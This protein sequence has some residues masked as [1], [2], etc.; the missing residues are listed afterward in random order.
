MCL[1]CVLRTGMV[2]VKLSPA[3][4]CPLALIQYP[5]ETFL[6]DDFYTTALLSV[7][8]VLTKGGDDLLTHCRLAQH[9]E[10]ASE[11]VVFFPDFCVL[12][13]ILLSVN[14]IDTGDNKNKNYKQK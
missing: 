5:I 10:S 3:C 11:T 4:C 9:H 1:N 13:P 6:T 14:Q 2:K 8:S 12:S 7:S